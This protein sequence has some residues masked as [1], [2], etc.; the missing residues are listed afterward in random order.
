MEIARRERRRNREA[1]V[2]YGKIWM[3]EKWWSWYEERGILVDRKGEGKGWSGEGKES[4]E[5]EKGEKRG[6]GKEGKVNTE[7]KKRN[8]G[9]SKRKGKERGKE[10]MKKKK[11]KGEAIKI[12]F[13]NMAGVKGK[14]EEFWEEIKRWDVIGLVEI[15]VKERE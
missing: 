1:W 12:G 5:M 6:R 2:R 15:W 8:R 3:Q 13:W 7:G 9:E 10:G 14:D 4:R 11:E